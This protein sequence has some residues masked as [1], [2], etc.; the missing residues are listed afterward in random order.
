[1]AE[2]QETHLSIFDSANQDVLKQASKG[3][4]IR[5]VAGSLREIPTL[6]RAAKDLHTIHKANPVEARGK[7]MHILHGEHARE[8]GDKGRFPHLVREI[9]YTASDSVLIPASTPSDQRAEIVRSHYGG[10][11]VPRYFVKPLGGTWQ[12][13]LADFESDDP[14]F[15]EYIQNVSED[16]LVQEFMP[17]EKV[18]RYMRYKD[19]AGK[20]F[21][22]AFEFAEDESATK[23]DLK[24]PFGDK[25]KLPS[26]GVNINEYA[27]TVANLTA[28]PLSNTHG[29]REHLDRFMDGFM[30]KLQD[31]LGGE[32]PFFS[33]DI[34]VKDMGVLEQPYDEEA[35][36]KGIVFFETQATPDSWEYRSHNIP[37]PLSTYVNLW[38]L[39]LKE[40][41]GEIL[42][43]TKELSNPK[44]T[45]QA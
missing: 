29:E 8:L 9:G 14:K 32:V 12:R 7:A 40:R 34:G 45:S 43:R 35:M 6:L 39:F 16:T 28:I 21:V 38:R 44:S 5:T 24:V 42:Q 23:K 27:T 4:G 20:V 25:V 37:K 31:K 17:H 1:M 18:L 10:K 19:K 41:G 15:N 13:D 26:H 3:N 30:N 11:D 22:A 33:C 36:K 2:G